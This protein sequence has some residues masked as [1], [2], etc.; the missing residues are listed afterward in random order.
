M[1][2]NLL[3]NI[4]RHSTWQSRLQYAAILHKGGKKA[5]YCKVNLSFF[6]NKWQK[7]FSY[8]KNV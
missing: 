8:E 3:V 7:I 4:S 6:M 2:I 1:L 5:L